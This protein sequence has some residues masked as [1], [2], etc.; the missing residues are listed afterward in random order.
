[1]ASSGWPM[2]LLNSFNLPGLPPH[3]LILKVGAIVV[4]L[5]NMNSSLGLANGTRLIDSDMRQ[6]VL[7]LRICTGDRAGSDVFLPRIPLTPS[8]NGNVQLP[9]KLTRLQF[10][11]RLAFGMTINKGQGQT[12][13]R[14]GI[15]LHCAAFSHGQFYVAASR[16]GDPGGVKVVIDHP[17]I[18]NHGRVVAE[19]PE[20]RVERVR[21]QSDPECNDPQVT[22]N[23]VFRPIFGHVRAARSM[24]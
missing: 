3:R 15:Y 2:E 21:R 20:E 6:S 16:S 4:L 22:A 1:M 9:F 18:D 5:R 10:P 17:P 23:I 24:I 7:K 8:D 14:V 11:V 19:T 13:E 12:F